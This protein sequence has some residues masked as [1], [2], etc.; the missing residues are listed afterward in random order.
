MISD[1]ER[2]III[3]LMMLSLVLLILFCPNKDDFYDDED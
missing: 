3:G 1:T 2:M